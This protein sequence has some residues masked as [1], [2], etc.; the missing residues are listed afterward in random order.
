MTKHSHVN[1]TAKVLEEFNLALAEEEA[2]FKGHCALQGSVKTSQDLGLVL[3]HI[4]A[5][6]KLQQVQIEL[7]ICL[8]RHKSIS[9]YVTTSAI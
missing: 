5:V 6:F 4:S 3:R 9:V 2:G 8:Y 1:V 7:W